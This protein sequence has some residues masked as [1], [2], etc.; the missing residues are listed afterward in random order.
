MST[1]ARLLREASGVTPASPTDLPRGELLRAIARMHAE[2]A[3]MTSEAD[4]QLR[5]ERAK[6]LEQWARMAGNEQRMLAALEET[7]GKNRRNAVQ[8][9]QADVANIRNNMTALADTTSP[10]LQ[11][12]LSAAITAGTGAGRPGTNAANI[13]AW[14]ALLGDLLN[15]GEINDANL[16]LPNLFRQMEMEGFGSIDDLLS[17]P[18]VETGS[19]LAVKAARSKRIAE[20]A[21]EQKIT[22]QRKMDDD[23]GALGG[24]I[25]SLANSDSNAN[26]DGLVQQASGYINTLYG[27]LNKFEPKPPSDAANDLNVYLAGN[28][29]FQELKK[30]TADLEARLDSTPGTDKRQQIAAVIGDPAFKE[31]AD[32]NGWKIGK[33]QY[34][35]ASGRWLYA[36]GKDDA[37]ALKT[38]EWQLKHDPQQLIHDYNTRTWLAVEVK[39]SGEDVSLQNSRNMA[40]LASAAGADPTAPLFAATTNEAGNPVYLTGEQLDSIISAR[41][42][43]L[44]ETFRVFQHKEGRLTSTYLYDPKTAT[45]YEDDG[46]TGKWVESKKT[47]AEV[48]YDANTIS[49]AAPAVVATPDGGYFPVDR[50]ELPQ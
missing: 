9:L 22:A 2:L 14:S 41:A 23:L 27:N 29:A 40:L 4:K 33:A 39:G 20:A 5:L 18:E 43:A 26:V 49:T 36:Q 8:F 30:S 46:K 11:K 1:Y 44:P 10:A 6:S 37:R 25:T 24:I 42:D 34:D 3:D 45:L 21:L 35:A 15:A 13:A 19:D 28:D 16:Q 31:W 17:L 48:G 38:Y 12:S 50:A 7:R 32:S 47:L